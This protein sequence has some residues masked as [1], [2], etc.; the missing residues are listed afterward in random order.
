[1]V[2]PA[3]PAAWGADAFESTEYGLRE[4]V[5]LAEQLGDPGDDADLVG[6][7]TRPPL[8]DDVRRRGVENLAHRYETGALHVAHVTKLALSM[9]DQLAELDL[10]ENDPLE[11]ELLWAACQVHD[12]G[13]KLD[14]DDHHRHARYILTSG[15]LP[16]FSP[17]ETAIIAQAARYHRRGNP[18]PGI[19]APLLHSG[20]TGRLLRI[21]TLLRLAEGLERGR[22]AAVRS[23]ELTAQGDGD[24][25]LGL[26]SY[27]E[28]QVP[29][30]AAAR[31]TELFERAYGTSLTVEVD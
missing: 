15:G 4:G 6:K 16:G 5:L 31:E 9:F 19:F 17:G 20:D 12:I 25:R 13:M 29:R 22:D 14:Y 30:W 11:R 7:N 18:S 1:V 23:V 3:P 26:T 10:Q 21:T 28:A 24:V 27:G 2:I 8:V